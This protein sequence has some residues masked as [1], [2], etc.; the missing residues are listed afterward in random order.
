MKF[1]DLSAADQKLLNTDLGEFEKDAAAQVA[2]ADEMYSVGFNKLATE[3]ADELDALM[4]SE[5]SASEEISLDEGSEKTASDL[6][7]FIERGFFD[8][9]CKLGQE[10]HGDAGIYLYPYIEEKVAE[11]GACNALNKLAK[12]DPE[13]HH[14]RRAFLSNPVSSAIE[15]KKGKKL[16]AFG[17]AYGNTLK[18]TGK[19]ALAGGTGGAAVGA[20]GALLSKGKIK[21]G[22]GAAMGG[23]LGAAGGSLAGSIK[24]E[25]GS[26]ASLIHGEFSK[27]KK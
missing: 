27:N 2:V 24:G 18:E 14:W 10:R 17:K 13:G 20:L 22:L 19:G 26:K 9:L 15:A 4:A 16:K 21:P 1:E 12:E 8:G 6:S 7:A 23:G 25:H 5:K 11:A 3:T